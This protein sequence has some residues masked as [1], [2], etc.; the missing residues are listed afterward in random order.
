[1][2]RLILALLCWHAAT[3]PASGA[4][5][6]ITPVA[7]QVMLQRGGG[8]RSQ[9]VLGLGGQRYPS[10]IMTCPTGA[11]SATR[12]MTSDQYDEIV[13]GVGGILS[14]LDQT[15]TSQR[16]PQADFAGCVLRLAGHDFM[17]FQ[18]GAGGGSDGCVDFD[19]ADNKGLEP[20]MASGQFVHSGLG[21]ATMMSIYQQHCS[22]V[23]LADFLV[24]SAEAVMTHT[25]R[26]A[27]ITDVPH[28]KAAFKFGR[29]TAE[30]C[31]F[32]KGRL[33]DAELGC[34]ATKEVFLTHLGLS[35][36]ESAALMGVHTLGRTHRNN[37]GYHGWWSD[38]ENSRKFNNNYY[39][40]LLSKSW[41]ATAVDGS[42]KHQYDRVDLGRTGHGDAG[43]QMMLN[44]DLCLAFGDTPASEAVSQARCTCTWLM[45]DEFADVVA[46]MPEREWCGT[47]GTI[48]TE[49]VT[50]EVV[51]QACCSRSTTG[52]SDTCDDLHAPTGVAIEHVQAFAADD[53]LWFEEFV[54]AWSK[55]TTVGFSHQPGILLHL[56]DACS[57]E[58][59]A[60]EVP[61]AE[62]AA[63][64][65]T[66]TT[67]ASVP[68]VLTSE[69]VKSR[70]YFAASMESCS[71]ACQRNGKQC[72]HQAWF[73]H[74]HELDSYA[75]MS[76]L[77]SEITGLERSQNPGAEKAFFLI[78]DGEWLPNF[79]SMGGGTTATA[80]A[81]YTGAELTP[82][83]IGNPWNQGFECG[84]D[85][86]EADTFMTPAAH[87]LGHIGPD[88]GPAYQCRY[89]IQ[90]RMYPMDQ[91]ERHYHGAS[92]RR[93]CVCED[94][95]PRP[96]AEPDASACLLRREHGRPEPD[97]ECCAR[98]SEA[99]CATGYEYRQGALCMW[100]H[101]HDY[102]ATECFLK[103]VPTPAPSLPSFAEGF[104]LGPRGQENCSA[105]CGERGMT[106]S[107]QGFRDV[108]GQIS[109]FTEV[110]RI[111]DAIG[112]RDWLGLNMEKITPQCLQDG[113]P[114]GFRLWPGLWGGS[115][116]Y[117]PCNWLHGD[118]PEDHCDPEFTSGN[119][120][121]RRLCKCSEPRTTTTTQ[122]TTSTTTS[123][124]TTA[125]ASG[126]AAYELVGDDAMCTDDALTAWNEGAEVGQWPRSHQNDLEACALR[127]DAT[128]GCNGFVFWSESPNERMNG[129]C[130]TYVACSR[131]LCEGCHEYLG[132]KAY[133]L[134]ALAADS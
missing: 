112:A 26:N 132:S 61:V 126:L 134:S 87:Y 55:A 39:V 6:V 80:A 116:H 109:N 59:L 3:A 129:H 7:E 133:R 70:W 25:R 101:D 113:G 82:V 48:G 21:N 29:R 51:S 54:A 78:K 128:S 58:D 10:S 17:D 102:F 111:V 105:V 28:F 91:C 120:G 19:D 72:N 131:L 104:F 100:S 32:A 95:E 23:S 69:A 49:P 118:V 2:T 117:M 99:S 92:W 40:S 108:Y 60:R 123:T 127:C 15:C 114:H 84:E 90:D 62:F 81:M 71:R 89:N 44:T 33:P 14:G 27:G 53:S 31:A 36:E 11:V 106:C 68:S 119:R 103:A 43:N 24:L 12:C 64:T 115:I 5:V 4:E 35:W 37:S 88:G 13:E 20:C 66:T 96:E 93:M 67:T 41:G 97:P 76:G 22:Q 52:A 45:P 46:A 38:P 34:R 107:A 18:W 47:T 1:M 79:T 16:C 42:E 98:P 65:T 9:R 77:L 122:T 110:S 124:T 57:A 30:S 75:K 63:T 56:K 94:A 85:V 130:R 125:G 83:G 121:W 73:T 50:E 86:G 74:G 8:Q